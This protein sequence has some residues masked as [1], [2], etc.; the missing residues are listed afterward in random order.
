MKAKHVIAALVSIVLAFPALA[1]VAP[2]ASAS[3]TGTSNGRAACGS[4]YKYVRGTNTNVTTGKASKK[5]VVEV[6]RK[7]TTFC[8]VTVRVGKAAG[9]RGTTTIIFNYGSHHWSE[10]GK[11]TY[12]AGPQKHKMAHGKCG[13]FQGRV[14][15]DVS[16]IFKVCA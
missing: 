11:F 13:L 16:P 15:N 1:L 10:S 12:Y 14:D 8:A 9:H 7:S 6:Y 5:M 3:T 4:G 2:A